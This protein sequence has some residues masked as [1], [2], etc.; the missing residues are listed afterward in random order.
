MVGRMPCGGKEYANH[1][2][3]GMI[4]LDFGMYR[5]RLARIQSLS[6]SFDAQACVK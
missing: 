6:P 5:T 3:A 2:I 4:P 1:H